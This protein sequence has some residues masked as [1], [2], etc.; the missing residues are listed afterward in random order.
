MNK[1]TE[2]KRQNL[3]WLLEQA[4]SEQ[5]LFLEHFLDLCRLLAQQIMEEEM[6][7]HAGARYSRTR[8]YEGRYDRY[9]FNPGSISVSN[10]RIAVDVPRLYDRHEQRCQPLQSYRRLQNSTTTESADKLMRAVLYGIGTRNYENCV[11]TLS[12]SFG[13]SRS[14]VSRQFIER[15]AVALQELQTRSL[16]KEEWTAVFLDGKRFG[17]AMMVV[18]LG[19]RADGRKC[20]L[21]IIETTT[22]N[23]EVCAQLLSGLQERGLTAKNGLLFIIDG[24]KGL[25]K[26][27]NKVYGKNAVVQRCQWHKRENVLS[28]L[29]ENE[30]IL[31]RKRLQNVYR[32]DD[33]QNAK[34]TL[35]RYAVLLE[36]INLSAA[37]ALR[38]GLEETLTLQRLGI[39]GIFHR[40]FSTTNCIESLNSMMERTTAQV[41]YWQNSDQRQRWVAASALD[42]E[43]RMRKVD[44]AKHLQM[45]RD[46]IKKDVITQHQ[47]TSRL[48]NNQP[49]STKKKT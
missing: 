13:L 5:A 11:E 32:D 12:E 22:E 27:I 30:Q 17:S 48:Q 25:R 42:A 3:A 28:Y 35:E 49:I 2:E 18:A 8:P 21:D 20:V 37:N 24:S 7:D 47:T 39:S 36:R 46:A 23:A 19:I 38:E 40:S 15:S 26:A 33:Y 9:G 6:R 43:G 14:S 34:T 45:L 29:P 44:N 4:P 31:W 41:K 16:D 1:S 10:Q